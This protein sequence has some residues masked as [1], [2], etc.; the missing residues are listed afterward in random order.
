M[1]FQS[2]LKDGMQAGLKSLDI[3]YSFYDESH[4]NYSG[5]RQA[6]IQYDQSATI[7]R[8]QNQRLLHNITVWRLG[9]AIQDGEISLPKGMGISD[10]NFEWRANGIPWIDPL[11]EVAA[12]VQAIN[13]K[14]RSRQ[15]IAGERG[16]D[17]FET[18]DQL[19]VEED[20]L[21]ANGMEAT[22]PT[23]VTFSVSEN[24]GN[25]ADSGK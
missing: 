13:A 5:S 15:Q 25:N 7:K 6:W 23:N 4:T 10:I 24:G 14:L 21:K 2:F 18:I 22:I 16:D 12:D 1:E 20:Y 19:K 11:K 17:W 3:P 8:S 9:L